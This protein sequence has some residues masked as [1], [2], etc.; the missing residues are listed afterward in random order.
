MRPRTVLAIAERDLRLQLQGRQRFVLPGLLLILLAPTIAVPPPEDRGTAMRVSGDVPEA[1]A[2]VPD[3]VVRHDKRMYN[4]FERSEGRVAVKGL[5]IPVPIREPLD[6]DESFDVTYIPP[7]PPNLPHRGLI[8][9]LIAAS[10]LSGSLAQSLAGER[11]ERT[12]V[13]LRATAVTPG[14]IVAGKW[15]AWGGFVSA[16]AMLAA[17][18]AIAW[19]HL[20]PG[21]WLMALPAPPLFAAALGM[22]L[23]RRAR[24]V[25]GGAAVSRSFSYS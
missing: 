8:L 14:E 19:G 24:D 25:V 1:V 20:E 9:S 21:R 12:L 6:A 7:E 23:L 4:H 13:S 5:A 2:A 18:G 15:L 11:S 17:L 22:W 3:V 16:I 10:T